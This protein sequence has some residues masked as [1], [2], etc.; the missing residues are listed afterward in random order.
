MDD[1]INVNEG[2]GIEEIAVIG[3]AGRFPGAK[4]IDQF[5]QNLCGSVESIVPFSDHELE[6][7]GV[8]ADWMNHPNFVKSGSILEDFDKFDA[9]FFGYSPVEAE[10]IDPQQRIFLETA[11]EALENAGYDPETYDCPIGVFAGSNPNE[12]LKL[13]PAVPD[14]NDVAAAMEKL[15]GNEKD[16]LCTRVSY[17]LNLRGPSVTLQ[18]GC[19][20]SLVAVHFACQSLLNYQCSL[21]LA[22]GVSLNLEHLRGYFYQDG[23]I[24]S[25]DGHC[26]AFDA[27]AQGTVLGQGVG[28]VI[29]KRLTEAAADG[30][31]IYAVIKGAAINN[32]GSLKAGYTAPSVDGQAE[33]IAMAQALSG[34]TADRISYIEAHGTGTSLGDPIEI[35]ALTQAFRAST[36]KK[37]FCS[38]GSVKT[39]IGHADAA[40]GIASFLKTVLMLYHKKIPANLHFE[41]P[42]PNIDFENSPFFV[43]TRLT[44]WKPDGMTRC[45]GVSSFGIGGTNVHAVLEEAPVVAKS[46][47]SR[48]QQLIVLSAYTSAALDSRASGL[49]QHLKQNPETNLADVAFTLQ[50]GRKTLN[51]RR[52]FVCRNTENAIAGLENPDPGHVQSVFQ[53]AISRDIVFMFSGQGA[54]YVNMGRKLYET[55]EVFREE[56]D[57]CSEILD[58][59]LSFDL[60][61]V[62]YPSSD[63]LDEQSLR[64]KQTLIAQPALFT[65]EYA[66][67]KLWMSWGIHPAAMIGH[68]IGEYVAACL[69]GVFSLE[70]ALL[71]VST[72]GRM[73]QS[74]PGGSMLA[75]PLSETEI[76][77]YLGVHLSLAAVNAPSFCVVSGDHQAVADLERKLNDNQLPS[78]RLHTSHGFHSKMMDSILDKFYETAKGIKL[79][80]PQIPIVSTVTGARVTSDEMERP[81]YWTKN[82]RQ[83]VRFSNCIQEL[84]RDEGKVFLE[85]GPGQTLCT[86]TRQ[87]MSKPGDQIIISSMRHPDEKKSD[88]GFILESLGKLWLCGVKP[89]WSGFYQSERRQRLPLPTYPFERQRY[90]PKKGVIATDRVEDRRPPEKKLDMNEWLSVPSWKRVPIPI[91]AEEKSSGQQLSWLVFLDD[92]GLGFSLADRLRRKGHRVTAVRKGDVFS[93]EPD[94]EYTLDP[95][96][97]DHYHDFLKTLQAEGR[98]PEKILH[99][100]SL[101]RSEDPFFQMDTYDLEKDPG[102]CSLLFLFQAIGEQLSDDPLELTVIT[103]HIQDVTGEETI[104]PEKAILL[105]PCRV[106]PHEYPHISC[107]TIDI[108]L[109]ENGSGK[110]GE[111]QTMLLRELL[112]DHGDTAVAYRGKHRWVQVFEPVYLKESGHQPT[113]LRDRGVYLI[114]GGLGG[115]GLEL[116]EYLA[117]TARARLVLISRRQ[118]PQKEVWEQWLS[119]HDEQDVTA[120]ILRKL[121][122]LEK[123]GAEVLVIAADVTDFDQMRAA[124]EKATGKFGAIHGVIHA[125]GLATGGAMQLRTLE[126][127]REIIDPK[128][129]G[130]KVLETLIGEASPDFFVLCSALNVLTGEAGQMDYCGANAFLDA[131][132]VKHHST[133]NVIAINWGTWQKVGM[134]VNTEVPADLKAE[135]ERN[136]K[137]GILPEEG[138][139]IFDRILGSLLPRVVVSP[140]DVFGRFAKEPQVI[141]AELVEPAGE[142]SQI[143][144]AHSRPELSSVFVLPGNPTEQTIADAWQALLKIDKVGIHDNFFEL[145]GHSLMATRLISKLKSLFTVEFK[146]ADIFERPTVNLLSELVLMDENKKD[147]FTDSKERVLKRKERKLQHVKSKRRRQFR[148]EFENA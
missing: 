94:G 126:A 123:S 58:P 75:V 111:L 132:A 39:N 144:P 88:T 130:T 37:R 66:L 127:A 120:Q 29:L 70:D 104:V 23:T 128:V 44:E 73:M 134:A 21:A 76:Q 131:Y 1:D 136:L 133:Q 86:L 90:W 72:R 27:K 61:K 41:K 57:R 135:R 2:D 119:S 52:M 137:F 148:E 85:V 56:I 78:T 9:P 42:N 5:W 10:N 64:L 30:D 145:G 68:S 71:L 14:F 84:I 147:S 13:L 117:C 122:R 108:S 4:N 62:L 15:I 38:I 18:T 45:A 100:W 103:N 112:S 92:A 121:Q 99:L 96:N 146:I 36:Q 109:S 106:V 31:T 95:G 34:V 47:P 80:S 35:A 142:S 105:G 43:S 114:T 115:V 33:V 65:I 28:A 116:A 16:F 7:K 93:C 77:P 82:L 26:R 51:Y 24:A 6:A 89:D 74:L 124:F 17:K 98:L 138:Q 69:A 3:L 19:S 55:E 141:G 101:T 81:E 11:W 8:P 83:T 60:R 67:A 49:L 22:G 48:P 143:E 107:T 32:D 97:P 40:A 139:E 140:R 50:T 118:F 63:N 12:Y 110:T 53:E 129:N 25:P 46:G 125:A 59:Y 79:K 91:A 102:F 54:Q 113:C 20:T 87:H